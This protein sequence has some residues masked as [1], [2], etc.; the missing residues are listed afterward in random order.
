LNKSQAVELLNQIISDCQSLTISGF[1]TRPIRFAEYESIEL[2]LF[3]SLDK[4]SRRKLGSIVASRNLKME[5]E[6]ELVI[7]YEPVNPT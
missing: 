6:K 1:Y 2:R 3:A 4:D 5:E 7:I